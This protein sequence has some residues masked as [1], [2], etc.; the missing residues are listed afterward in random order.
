MSSNFKIT[1]EDKENLLYLKES[2]SYN[3]LIK[4]MRRIIEIEQS[5]VLNFNLNEKS[6]AQL[7]IAKAK[8][9]GCA[10]MLNKFQE[11]INRVVASHTGGKDG[12]KFGT[13]NKRNK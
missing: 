4:M 3:T 6:F 10:Y 7:A 8:A 9:E 13:R 12:S 2:E 5:K 1:N 11:E